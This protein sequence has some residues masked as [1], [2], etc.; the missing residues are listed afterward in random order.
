MV[1]LFQLSQPQDQ[2]LHQLPNLKDKGRWLRLF[3]LDS[4]LLHCQ[5]DLT[6]LIKGVAMVLLEMDLVL[7]LLHLAKLE[8]VHQEHP[9]QDL[10]MVHLMCQV[11]D[12]EMTCL[13]ALHLD[14]QDQQELDLMVIK[15]L[16]LVLELDLQETLPTMDLL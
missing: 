3:L 13:E 4:P 2:H 11:M 10:E 8:L 15:H 1:L 7:N 5:M 14:C 16:E 9:K 6:Q 12:L